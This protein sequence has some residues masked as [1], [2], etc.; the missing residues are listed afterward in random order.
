PYRLEGRRARGIGGSTLH[1]EGYALRFHA[2][3]FRVRSLYGI[4][5]DWPISY[6]D[7]ET[8]YGAAERA[9]GVAG[10]EGEGFASHR[11]TAFPL[12]AFP[13]SYSDGL[14]APACADLRVAL[15]HLPQ[16]RNSVAYGGRPPC[17]ACATCKVCP[18]GAKASVDL[19]HIPQAEATGKAELRPEATALR[20]E[21]DA[22]GRVKA[23]VYAGRDR[24]ERRVGAEVFV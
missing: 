24:V 9:L 15:Q 16:A 2:N 6:A 7:L 3:D 21:S 4:G 17:A 23:V 13:F 8:Y 19:T 14:F 11:S 18:T 12:P 10:S 22:S 1:W 20:L 5:E